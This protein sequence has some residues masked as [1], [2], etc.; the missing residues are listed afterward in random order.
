MELILARLETATESQ[1]EL[2]KG[3]TRVGLRLNLTRS[4]AHLS[5]ESPRPADRVM[6]FMGRTL[7]IVDPADYSR[8]ERTRL[9]V[10]RGPNGKTLSIEPNRAEQAA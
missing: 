5:L 8:L 10:E 1:P 9:T 6:S 2:R 3:A 7:L 4:G